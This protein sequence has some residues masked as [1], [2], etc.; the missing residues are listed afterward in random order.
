MINTIQY[1]PGIGFSD[2]VC[3]RFDL[4]CYS[5]CSK[6]TQPR[7]NLHQADFDKLTDLIQEVN[8]N[9][10]LSPL[11]IHC[12][13]KLFATKFTYFINECIPYNIPRTKSIL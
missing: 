12:A 5:T 4:L 6:A 3:L 10:T 8:W 7:Y 1:L 2:H 9:D 11:N 13:W